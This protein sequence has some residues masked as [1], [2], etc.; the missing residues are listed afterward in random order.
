MVLGYSILMDTQTLS[1]GP[2]AAL[3]AG[4]WPWWDWW[5]D[6]KTRWVRD[7]QRQ[8]SEGVFRALAAGTG[9]PPIH[10]KSNFAFRSVRDGADRFLGLTRGG[11]RPYARIYTRLGNPTTEYLER[12]LF[13]LEAHHVVE[14]ALADDELEPT[15]GTLIFSSG[16]GAVSALFALG[17]HCRRHGARGQRVRLHGQPPAWNGQVR[18]RVRLLRHGQPRGRRSRPRRAPQRLARLPREPREPDP[19]PGRHRAH[20][21]PDRG[22]RDPPRRRQHILL[23]LPPAALPARG[24]LRPALADE[25]RQRALDVG[26]RRR[27]RP[28]PVHEGAVSSPGTR[29]WGPPPRPS[30]RG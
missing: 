29:T 6:R 9:L 8:L 22:A 13:Q 26:R 11:E 5:I 3:G 17:P 14:K 15:I 28:V 1:P 19:A 21:A 10:Q 4:R 12:V 27:A 25:V 24:G 20:L 18:R 23:P 2:V 16:M 7:E 30:T